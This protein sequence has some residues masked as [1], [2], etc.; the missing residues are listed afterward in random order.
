M[1]LIFFLLIIIFLSGCDIS[2]KN[3][4]YDSIPV[5]TLINKKIL[6]NSEQIIRFGGYFIL[7]NNISKDWDIYSPHLL[8]YND[9]L[10][11]SC[12][13]YFASE[14][15]DSIKSNII[16]G[17]LNQSRL[18]RIN[19]FRHDLP[20]KFHINLSPNQRTTLHQSNKMVEKITINKSE[21]ILHT[22]KS[23]NKFIGLRWDVKNYKETF[24]HA[25]KQTDSLKFSI[26]DLHFNSN[27]RI[28]SFRF[29]D[30]QNRVVDDDMIVAKK[31]VLDDFYNQIWN[32]IIFN[33]R[34]KIQ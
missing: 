1:K 18:K 27:G 3:D 34:R 10:R 11:L 32:D 14:R 5:G 15:I 7:V 12:A 33:H 28:I 25:Y 17:T 22:R 13:Y 26:S 2:R 4:I 19:Q 6:I 23:E 9:S 30:K 21:I 24:F 8:F 31:S 20:M 29:I 16:Y